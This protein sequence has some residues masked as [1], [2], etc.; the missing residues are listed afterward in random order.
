MF[1]G[2]GKFRWS[3]GSEYEGLWK[4]NEMKGTGTKKLKNG[5]VEI[6]GCFDGNSVNGKGYKKWKRV[7]IHQT[8][9]QNP[10]QN[11]NQS[12]GNA[13]SSAMLSKNLSTS[14]HRVTE[15]YIYRGT[16]R[17]SRIEGQGEFKWPDS[18]HYIGEFVN[19]CM[20]GYGKLIWHDAKVNP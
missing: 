20:E 9:N 4:N 10:Q 13:T 5:M 17:D 7:V 2:Q 19:S 15:V 14:I 18:R 11:L 8:Q 16:M 3:D 1:N 12:L 6:H